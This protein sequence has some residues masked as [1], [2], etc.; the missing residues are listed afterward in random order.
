LSDNIFG[1][2]NDNIDDTMPIEAEQIIQTRKI[3]SQD[4]ESQSA[5]ANGLPHW[6]LE[7]PEV[8]VRRKTRTI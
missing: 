2:V 4:T 1:Q 3:S 6:S 5:L 8:L 7:P